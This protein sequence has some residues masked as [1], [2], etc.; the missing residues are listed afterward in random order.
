MAASNTLPGN[1]ANSAVDDVDDVSTSETSS[2]STSLI[3][4]N[5]VSL[6]RRC[7]DACPLILVATHGGV[8]A[9]P[10]APKRTKG[11][12]DGDQFTRQ[13]TLAIRDELHRLGGEHCTPYLVLCD[14]LRLYVDCNRGRIGDRVLNA[15]IAPPPQYMSDTLPFEPTARD[16]V[17]PA[18]A[19]YD[20]FHAAILARI[21]H[22]AAQGKRAFL[23][24]IHGNSFSKL[25]GTVYITGADSQSTGGRPL[26]DELCRHFE[27]A[28]VCCF[29]PELHDGDGVFTGGYINHHYGRE[30][31]NCDAL[32][33]EIH[34]DFRVDAECAIESGKKMAK[35]LY[36]YLK[37]TQQPK[38]DEDE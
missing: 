5:H 2:S 37:E 6:S 25:K 7:S 17:N 28:D 19:T 1:A 11:V 36:E 24:D 18:K 38:Q 20:A 26:R 35:A 32:Q 8:D 27:R 13:L 12:I 22:L 29:Q 31:D 30:V 21:E 33:I 16:C 14:A 4:A 34:R 15:S 9:I 23:L 10:S 3:S